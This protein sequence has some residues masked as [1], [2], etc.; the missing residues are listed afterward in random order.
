MCM[1]FNIF[2]LLFLLRIIISAMKYLR[3]L[4]SFFLLK[5]NRSF[6]IMKSSLKENIM[7]ITLVLKISTKV[8]SFSIANT[9]RF[10]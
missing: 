7:E 8:S 2:Y 3:Y 6:D 9:R 5:V 10:S 1:K 4:F